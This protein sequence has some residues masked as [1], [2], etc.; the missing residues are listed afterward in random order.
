M[1]LYR[2]LDKAIEETF[3]VYE[4]YI[5]YDN[6]CLE[7]FKDIINKASE[8][9]KKIFVKVFNEFLN[10]Y[11]KY[12]HPL[13]F[14]GLNHLRTF[15]RE[16]YLSERKAWF[17]HNIRIFSDNK[18]KSYALNIFKTFWKRELTSFKK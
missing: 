8:T 4:K 9:D 14:N 5:G 11:F 10:H 2:D 18:I 6:R 3:N 7:V 13:Y 17:E 12:F 1:K 15:Y 16:R